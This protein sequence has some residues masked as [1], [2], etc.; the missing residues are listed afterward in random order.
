[1]F[2]FGGISFIVHLLINS[3][4]FAK[5]KVFGWLGLPSRPA[6]G[7]LTRPNRSSYLI[8]GFVFFSMAAGATIFTAGIFKGGYYNLA[9]IRT[10]ISNFHPT[11]VAAMNVAAIPSAPIAD[12]P[13]SGMATKPSDPLP[14]VENP[15]NPVLDEEDYSETVLPGEGFWQTTYR[16]I[17]RMT[18]DQCLNFGNPT[19]S[20]QR[21]N[22][23]YDT[24][25][26]N[27]LIKNGV[28]KN[29]SELRIGQPGARLTLDMSDN[30]FIDG[31]LARDSRLPTNK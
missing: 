12:S 14:P 9:L 5:R 10:Q 17:E 11:A 24:L 6:Y 29:D 30:L 23:Y 22:H 15:K 26:A 21:T 1:M 28:L 20:C 16:L 19:S 31:I 27:L 3:Y 25:T 8:V 13:D 18:Q 2:S 7:W 4:C